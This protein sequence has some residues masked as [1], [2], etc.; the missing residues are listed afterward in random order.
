M[1]SSPIVDLDPT[2]ESIPKVALRMRRG[3]QGNR[4]R[5]ETTIFRKHF[6]FVWLSCTWMMKINIAVPT[7]TLTSRLVPKPLKMNHLVE[8]ICRAN[9]SDG[10]NFSKGTNSCN[11]AKSI[12]GADSSSGTGSR[13]WSKSSSYNSGSLD[14]NSIFNSNSSKKWN[15]Y[16]PGADEWALKSWENQSA[17]LIPLSFWSRNSKGGLIE[18]DMIK[19]SRKLFMH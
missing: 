8:F 16:S 13:N 5:N 11:G 19:E 2:L 9:S 15:Q 1:D 14:S 12:S 6:K 17:L 4:N 10:A 7:S 18:S 3:E